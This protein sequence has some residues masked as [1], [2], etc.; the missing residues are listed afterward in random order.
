MLADDIKIVQITEQ[1]NYDD[2]LQPQVFIRVE[3]KVARHGP[4][5]EKF[6][7][8]DYT[9]D[10]RDARLNTFGESVRTS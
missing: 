1:R 4:F 9:V 2:T 10:V 7:K 8:A 6:P 5:V 3:F